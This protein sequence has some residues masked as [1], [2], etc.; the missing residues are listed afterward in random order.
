[1]QY[2]YKA[3]ERESSILWKKKN[4]IKAVEKEYW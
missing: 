2:S 1:M 3:R 4:L